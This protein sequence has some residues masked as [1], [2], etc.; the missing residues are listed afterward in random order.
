MNIEIRGVMYHVEAEGIT[1]HERTAVLLHGFSG[2]SLDWAEIAT[3]LRAMDRGVVAIDLV[4]HGKT[5]SPPDPARYTLAETA[6]DLDEI[7]SRLGVS[8][9]DWV[10]YSMGGRVAL[11]VALA[12]PTRVR[13]LVLESASAGIEVALEL[14]PCLESSRVGREVRDAAIGALVGGEV[15]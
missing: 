10:G 7:A 4:G 11:H 2:S 5:Q 13:S 3:K 15:A 6:R 9:A 1:S 8:E 14:R 12:H